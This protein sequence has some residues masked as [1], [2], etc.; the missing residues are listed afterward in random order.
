[1]CKEAGAWLHALPNKMKAFQL[2]DKEFRTSLLF[3]LFMEQ[4]IPAGLRCNCR[5]HPTI[6]KRGHHL[7]TGCGHGG[8][9][10]RAHD[11]QV[12]E[13]NRCLNYLNIMTRKEQRHLF[14]EFDPNDNHIPDITLINPPASP[15]CAVTP[16]LFDISISSPIDGLNRGG[17]AYA[18]MSSTAAKQPCRAANERA[19]AK[20]N[21]YRPLCTPQAGRP[22][23]FSFLAF[24][25]ETTGRIHPKSLKFIKL[26]CDTASIHKKIDSD[27]IYTYVLKRLSV[28]FQKSMASTVSERIFALTTP[29]TTYNQD[30]SFDIQYVNSEQPF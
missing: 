19:K 11:N 17:D 25:Y 13:V 28:C 12:A 23:R 30:H 16:L 9:R 21:K 22:Q 26:C 5:S 8:C 14:K 15:M 1:M 3:R 20:E 24:I 6:D 18:N 27:S 4:P 2:S 29:S 7:L 10:I